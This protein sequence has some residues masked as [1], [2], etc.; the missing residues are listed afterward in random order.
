MGIHISINSNDYEKKLSV[1]NIDKAQFALVNQV[2]ADM[3]LYAPRREGHLRDESFALDSRITYKTPYAKAQYRGY[4]TS[5]KGKKIKF[6]N[7]STPGTG[8][9]WDKKAKA[10][11][12]DSW[13]KA[14]VKG[15]KF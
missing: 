11:H 5:K 10:N 13:C 9:H 7:Y 2:H 3:N 14:F 4:I 6:K 1:K 12:I 15:G 8:S